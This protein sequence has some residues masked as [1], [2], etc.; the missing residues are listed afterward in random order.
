M[1]CDRVAA[2][3]IFYGRDYDEEKPFLYF[4]KGRKR[5]WMH[6]ETSKKLEELLIMLRDQ[7]EEATFSYIKQVVKKEGK[8]D[9]E[10]WK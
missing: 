5:R 8:K 4:D 3:K 7:G 10:H 6:P 2:S 9:K 1:F